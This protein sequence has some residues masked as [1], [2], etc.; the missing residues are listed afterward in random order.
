M[1]TFAAAFEAQARRYAY[2]NCH[3]R[4]EAL[5]NRAEIGGFGAIGPLVITERRVHMPS[6]QPT[7]EEEA[8]NGEFREK[9][10]ETER[11]YQAPLDERGGRVQRNAENHSGLGDWGEATRGLAA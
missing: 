6:K 4:I 10:A 1:A 3:R 11:R 2:A 9:P 5:C 7:N 8:A